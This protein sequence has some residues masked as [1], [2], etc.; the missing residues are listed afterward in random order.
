M[1]I[2][3]KTGLRTFALDPKTYR[4]SLLHL[5]FLSIFLFVLFYNEHQR[6]FQRISWGSRSSKL[7]STELMIIGRSLPEKLFMGLVGAEA[8]LLLFF[9]GIFFRNYFQRLALQGTL[10]WLCASPYSL[11]KILHISRIECSLCLIYFLLPTLPLYTICFILGLPW[12]RLLFWGF[13]FLFCT[14]FF[15]L[16]ASIYLALQQKTPVVFYR[17]LFVFSIFWW[18]CSFFLATL[19]PYFSFYAIA[20]VGPF[21]GGFYFLKAQSAERILLWIQ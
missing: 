2:I 8:I 21:L 5:T 14:S 7:F 17:N 20:S 18:L 13:L 15:S 4:W 3:L 12:S 6:L 10:E 1:P 9:I 11:K 16:E 19:Y